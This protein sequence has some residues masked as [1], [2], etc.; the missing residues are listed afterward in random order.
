MYSFKELVVPRT[1][2][3]V[4]IASIHVKTRNRKIASKVN[5]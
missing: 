3:M 4:A 5:I 1:Y 2:A